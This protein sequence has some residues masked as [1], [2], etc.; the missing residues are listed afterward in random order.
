MSLTRVSELRF[1]VTTSSIVARVPSILEDSTA[2]CRVSDEISISGAG[3]FCKYPINSERRL[4]F[5]I[6]L[7]K[8]DGAKTQMQTLYRIECDIYT[9]LC[10]IFL[11]SYR[12]THE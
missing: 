4:P 1:S 12:D 5:R 11:K 10:G 8:N 3:R 9:D 7:G 6:I 2:S